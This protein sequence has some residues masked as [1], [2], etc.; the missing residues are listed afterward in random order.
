MWHTYADFADEEAKFE[1]LAARFKTAELATEF[2][3]AFEQCQARLG[4]T[5]CAPG[6]IF[7]CILAARIVVA[8]IVNSKLNKVCQVYVFHVKSSMHIKIPYKC[9]LTN[10]KQQL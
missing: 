10:F 3:D 6:T 4:D 2:K 5:S 9:P 8:R 7:R 1:Q